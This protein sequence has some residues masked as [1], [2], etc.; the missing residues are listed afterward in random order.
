M[1]EGSITYDFTLYLR[2]HDHPTWI[3]KCPGTTFRHFLLG[4]HNFM[5]IALGL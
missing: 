2:V 5:V 1:V 4:S 3:W